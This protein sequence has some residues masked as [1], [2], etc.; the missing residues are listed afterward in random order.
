MKMK[1]VLHISES[2]AIPEFFGQNNFTEQ[3]RGQYPK[4]ILHRQSFVMQKED[5]CTRDNKYRHT[6]KAEEPNSLSINPSSIVEKVRSRIPS[7]SDM[8][9]KKR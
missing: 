9:K 5:K 8:I 7:R 6:S 3:S 1:F 4:F 2:G